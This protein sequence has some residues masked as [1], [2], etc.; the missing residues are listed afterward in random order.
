MGLH[1]AVRTAGQVPES[2]ASS[3]FTQQLLSITAGRHQHSS[4]LT[5]YCLHGPE[6]RSVS[7]SSSTSQRSE[8][9]GNDELQAAHPPADYE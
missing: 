1:E 3:Q 6:E 7:T 8:E 9:K 5:S 2:Q 4:N